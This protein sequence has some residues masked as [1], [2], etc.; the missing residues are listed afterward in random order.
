MVNFLEYVSSQERKRRV[1]TASSPKEKM[2]PPQDQKRGSLV[3]GT[4]K[5]PIGSRVAKIKSRV[6]KRITKSDSAL[7][8]VCCMLL[9]TN[10]GRCLI[11]V[12][13]VSMSDPARKMAQRIAR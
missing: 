7:H 3:C 10:F 1:R 5:T 13:F 9:R 8:K 6:L 4:V 11:F 2:T 12:N